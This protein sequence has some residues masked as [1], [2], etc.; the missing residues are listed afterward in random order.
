M[1]YYYYEAATTEGRVTRKIL[2]AR[3]KKDADHRLRESGLR[4]MLI[5]NFRATRKK[6]EQKAL[7][8][9]HI[10]RNTLAVVLGISLVGGVAVYLMV[11]DLSSIKSHEVQELADRGIID[12]IAPSAI[13]ASGEERPFA[14]GVK[15]EL[16]AAYPDTFGGITIENHYLML[17]YVKKRNNL[18]DS[19][20][21]QIAS[22]LATTFQKRF[23]LKS[24]MVQMVYNEKTIAQA[25]FRL[26]EAVVIDVF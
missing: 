6:K 16:D 20:L 15:E 24:C 7:H 8:T 12:K 19:D 10:I 23:D 9:R 4:P 14:N 5:E 2:K 18:A 21:R 11:L 25:R 17:I 13:V 3:D 26:G 1:P 22:L